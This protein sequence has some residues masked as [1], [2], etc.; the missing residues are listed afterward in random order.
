MLQ[1]SCRPDSLSTC[2]DKHPSDCAEEN[3][4]QFEISNAEINTA[5]ENGNLDELNFEIAHP[6]PGSNPE[7]VKIFGGESEF[8]P[9]LKISYTSY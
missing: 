1:A 4:Y 7:Q 6:Y 8:P 2:F 9:T 3:S 5:L